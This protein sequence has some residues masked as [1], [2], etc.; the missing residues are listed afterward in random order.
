MP[1]HKLTKSIGEHYVCA[2]LAQLGWAASLT[3]DGLKRT[4]ILA[5]N[6][7]GDVVQVQVKTSTTRPEPNWQVG[8]IAP[9]RSGEWYVLVGLGETVTARPSF[10]VV[11]REHLRAA[12]WI[13]H[14]HWRYDPQVTQGRRNTPISRARL[15]AGDVAGYR[16]AWGLLNVPTP[17]VLLGRSMREHAEA[18]WVPLPPE[19][20]PWSELLPEWPDDP[21]NAE[22]TDAPL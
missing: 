15:K 3:R 5:V 16:E 18:Y 19:G 9:G 14:H 4:D 13:G 22:P 17:P 20:K 1:D 11:P 21:C 2:V 12:A 7:A 8:E 10:W 6:E